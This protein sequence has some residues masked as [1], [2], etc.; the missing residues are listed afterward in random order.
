MF[1]GL[2]VDLLPNLV[3]QCAMHSLRSV[4]HGLIG[5]R[6]SDFNIDTSVHYKKNYCDN[7]NHMHNSA[8]KMTETAECVVK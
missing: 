1:F 8:W 3:T 2:F 7:A 5:G 4:L 6:R